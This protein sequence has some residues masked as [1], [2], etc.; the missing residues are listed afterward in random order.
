M[1]PAAGVEA[2]AGMIAMLKTA[3]SLAETTA[4]AL[5]KQRAAVHQIGDADCKLIDIEIAGSVPRSRHAEL[6]SQKRDGVQRLAAARI[7]ELSAQIEQQNRQIAQ[8]NETIAQAE[9]PLMG[10]DGRGLTRQ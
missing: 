7:L 1:N 10:L 6:L 8:L 3:R 5:T 4:D 2:Q 9:A